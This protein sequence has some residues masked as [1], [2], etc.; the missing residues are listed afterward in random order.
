MEQDKGKDLTL[1]EASSVVAGLGV[2]GGIM[3]VPYLAGLNGI[4]QVLLIM[5]FAYFISAVLHL[6]VAETV[7]RGGGQLQLVELF[8]KYLFRGRAGPALTWIFFALIVITFFSLLAGYIAGCGEIIHELAGIPDWA[9]QVITYAVAAGIVFF[10]LKA[11]GVSEKYA[12]I[13]IAVLLAALSVGSL[14]KPF[15]SIPLLHG[16]TKEALA[17]YGMVM[18]SFACFFSIPQ[19]VE[20]LSRKRELIPW[21]VTLGI[22]INF[23]F[24]LT[25]TAMAMLVSEEVTKIAIIGWGEAVGKWALALGSLSAFLAMLTSYWAVSYALAVIVKER[26][27]WSYRASWLAATL[28]TIA[29][30]LS[31]LTDFLGFMRITGGAVAVM[32]AVMVVPA[33][34]ASRRE[35]RTGEDVFS[36]GVLGGTAL[37]AA[38]IL[39]YLIMA[40]GSMVPLE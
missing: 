36:M 12:I 33:L 35:G 11:I 4:F 24:V 7:L 5:L 22:G 30:A 17:L 29:I 6:M 9:G 14:G 38:V 15:R 37:Q 28:P 3:A 13:G 10:G 39:A 8:G 25:L 21:S 1:F 18:F 20:G 27:S 32:V 23:A 2:G 31:G 34:R 40:V 19:A 26:L 16:G